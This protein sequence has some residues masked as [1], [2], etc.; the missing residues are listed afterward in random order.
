MIGGWLRDTSPFQKGRH[1][2]RAK[3]K[4]DKI[5]RRIYAFRLNKP[6]RVTSKRGEGL[7]IAPE[8]GRFGDGSVHNGYV[9]ETNTGEDARCALI[10]RFAR[11]NQKGHR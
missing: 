11:S 1:G 6:K 5:L 2:E 9:T 4:P 8:A 3:R 10:P 7:Q